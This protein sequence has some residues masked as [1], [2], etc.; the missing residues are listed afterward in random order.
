[1]Y[2]RVGSNAAVDLTNARPGFCCLSGATVYG[3]RMRNPKS[4][5]VVP[6]AC[7][8]AAFAQPAWAAGV[9]AIWLVP[10][11][12]IVAF[13]MFVVSLVMSRNRSRLLLLH[14]ANVIG[15]AMVAYL[16]YFSPEGFFLI[17]FYP[18]ASTLLL[19]V[20]VLVQRNA[21]QYSGKPGGDSS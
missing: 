7:F 18:V 20:F 9:D 17:V 10:A 5:T 3:K 19:V 14:V 4:V 8:L 21:A 11:S 16:E 2:K 12:W 1:M 15:Y 6:F 13:V